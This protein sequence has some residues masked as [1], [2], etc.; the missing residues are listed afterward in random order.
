[1]PLRPTFDRSISHTRAVI[2]HRALP[3]RRPAIR[4]A[5][6]AH[7]A[8]RP[9][10]ASLPLTTPKLLP[11]A[12]DAA[13]SRN[14]RIAAD[15]IG[16][17]L[18]EGQSPDHISAR[19]TPAQR[20]IFAEQ[21]GRKQFTGKKGEHAHVPLTHHDRLLRIML[22]GLG[23][24]NAAACLEAGKSVVQ[25]SRDCAAKHVVMVPPPSGAAAATDAV[26][27]HLVRGLRLGSYRY[28]ACKSHPAAIDGQRV[29]V[30]HPR[31][32]GPWVEAAQNGMAMAEATAMARDLVNM[33]ANRLTPAAFADIAAREAARY[34]LAC[35]I[36]DGPQLEARGMGLINAVGGASINPPRLVHLSYRPAG[37][38]SCAAPQV[39]LVGKGITFDSGGLCIK[40]ANSM[41]GMKSDMGGA[42]AAFGAIVGAARMDAPIGVDAILALAENSISEAAY[43]PGDVYTSLAGKSVEIINTDAEGGLVLADAL[44]FARAQGAREIIDVATLTGA[45]VMA[46]GNSTAGLFSNDARLTA[47][48]LQAANS[49]GES[50]WHMPLS[51][52][53][54]PDLR[55]RIADLKNLGGSAG[56]AITAALFLREFVGDT[57]WAHLD[58]AGPATDNDGG[59][60]FAAATLA[61][62]LC[63]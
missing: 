35:R 26:L 41:L 3:S 51:E 11:K 48:L 61:A 36:F 29:A 10:P 17:A 49:V 54:E 14:A 59:T 39:A 8:A 27:T 9:S 46:L 56:G 45:C 40:P 38:P 63:A 20:H 19:L 43:R 42:A 6:A 30:A 33:P 55:S 31:S 60:G 23:Q 18:W 15:F 34:G 12:L 7:A 62:Y 28:S 52:S 24:P 50:I 58:I 53:L 44:H 37:A 47:D 21:I 25:R 32:G 2:N 13:F 57:P 4:G 22:V 16:V 1:M 5:G